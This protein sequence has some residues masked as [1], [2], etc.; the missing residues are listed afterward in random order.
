MAKALKQYQQKVTIEEYHP[1]I[2][3]SGIHKFDKNKI[4]IDT[5][6]IEGINKFFEG[7][8]ITYSN[9]PSRANMEPIKDSVW[10]AKMKGSNKIA[11]ITDFDKD[12]L[13][14]M[15]LSTGFMG[16]KA[17]ERLPLSLLFSIVITDDFRT[18]RDL[19][20]VGTTM[21]GINN[22]TFSKMIVPKLSF[23]EIKAFDMRYKPFIFELST[24][25]RKIN[26]L[27][28]S[29]KILLKKYF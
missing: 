4:Y 6:T 13:D 9:R 18:Q 25:R 23:D 15:I 26:E 1:E 28:E 5:S 17:N 3:K 24:L 14:Y 22:E 19:N 12:I 10:F 7:D 27:K 8:S 29:K 20:S 21:A 11:L 16:I 2:I